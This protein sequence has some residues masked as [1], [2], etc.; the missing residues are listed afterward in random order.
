MKIIAKNKPGDGN[1]SESEDVRVFGLSE[2]RMYQH[3]TEV[4]PN[5]EIT[6]ISV[7][8]TGEINE[9]KGTRKCNQYIWNEG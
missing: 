1:W 3:A 2:I 5:G 4:V 8:I 6:P 9:K 7:T